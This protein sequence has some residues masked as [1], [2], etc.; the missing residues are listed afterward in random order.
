MLAVT[1]LSLSRRPV[2]SLEMAMKKIKR[3]DLFNAYLSL[4]GM[5]YTIRK[6]ELLLR[7]LEEGLR[8]IWG[9]FRDKKVGP[10]Y[11]LQ[12]PESEPYFKNKIRLIYEYDKRDLVRIVCTMFPYILLELFRSVGEEA[13]PRRVFY[14]SRKFTGPAAS[15]IKRYHRIL[16][17]ISKTRIPLLVTLATELH[18]KIQALCS[19]S[20]FLNLQSN[21]YFCV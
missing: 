8:E 10:S 15:W 17:F 3:P 13:L 18:Q 21:Q 19:L 16:R 14:E 6:A 4:Y 7:E 12:Q 20:D 2:S 1:K 9:Y 11:I 5:P